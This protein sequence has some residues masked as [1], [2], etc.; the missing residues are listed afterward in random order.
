MFSRGRSKP[1]R[2]AWK[3]FHPDLA[4]LPQC[5][6]EQYGRWLNPYPWDLWTTLTFR[7]EPSPASALRSFDRW[8]SRSGLF[9]QGDPYWFVATENGTLNGRCHLHALI[10]SPGEPAR[11]ALWRAWWEPA[12]YKDGRKGHRGRAEILP[13]DPA[14]GASFYIG[15]YI[16]K[17]LGEW[18]VGGLWPV[19]RH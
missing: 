15:K 12:E 17:R 18:Q 1:S 6:N 9:F 7:T 16:T 5:T 14:L 13:Y 11:R 4:E 10:G 19:A 8:L 3:E 2:P